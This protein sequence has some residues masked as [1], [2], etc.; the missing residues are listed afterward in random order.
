MVEMPSSYKFLVTLKLTAPR[1]YKEFLSG[2][3]TVTGF[4][5][6]FEVSMKNIGKNEFPGGR[7]VNDCVTFETYHGQAN[8]GFSGRIVPSKIVKLKPGDVLAV[9]GTQTFQ[10]PGPWRVVVNMKAKDNAKINY[11]Q[12]P[13]GLPSEEGFQLIYVADHH[14]LDLALLLKKSMKSR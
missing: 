8:I 6:K 12:T 7:L 5:T 3:E 14:Q 13:T 9:E 2:Y 11:Y 1:K 4:P 10:I